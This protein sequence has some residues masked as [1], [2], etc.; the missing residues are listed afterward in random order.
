MRCLSEAAASRNQTALARSD[1]SAESTALSTVEITKLHTRYVSVEFNSVQSFLS[2]FMSNYY[3]FRSLSAFMSNYYLFRSLSAFMSNYYL[4][5]EDCTRQLASHCHV[6]HGM[7]VHSVTQ[8]HVTNR[9]SL[10]ETHT[11]PQYD[12]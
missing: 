12:P 5:S 8:T 2:A 1:C 9:V 11:T 4:F 3:L 6:Q 7:T 10:G